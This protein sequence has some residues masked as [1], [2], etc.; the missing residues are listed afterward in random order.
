[1]KNVL[2]ESVVKKEEYGTQ[3]T[4]MVYG[5]DK[6]SEQVTQYT[7]GANPKD[8]VKTILHHDRLGSVGFASNAENGSILASA[9]Y[10]AWGN[11]LKI[12]PHSL[13]GEGFTFTQY[14]VHDYDSVLDVYFA[15]ARMYDARNR[16]FMAEDPVKGG[17]HRQQMAIKLLS[18]NCFS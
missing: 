18:M 13:S 3:D 7:P 8:I 9:S 10:D 5:L 11:P 6:V 14:T 2:I 17:I 4:R 16:R 15:N 12:V 1:L